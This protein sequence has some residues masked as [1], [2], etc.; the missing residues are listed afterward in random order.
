[1]RQRFLAD[2]G[3]SANPLKR[4]KQSIGLVERVAAQLKA[5]SCVDKP[6]HDE[7]IRRMDH[8]DVACTGAFAR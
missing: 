8:H 2:L 6:V 1:M 4:S 7:A 3:D 5:L